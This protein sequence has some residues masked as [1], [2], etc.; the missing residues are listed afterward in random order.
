MTCQAVPNATGGTSS[1]GTALC[2]IISAL[3]AN[4]AF[5]KSSS[6]ADPLVYKLTDLLGTAEVGRKH[7]NRYM[8]TG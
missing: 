3:P 1:T 5:S 2:A 6:T 4:N 7:I 8:C